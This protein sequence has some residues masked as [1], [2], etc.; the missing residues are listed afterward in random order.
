LGQNIYRQFDTVIKLHR[1]NRIT[2]PIWNEILQRAR[3]GTCTSDDLQEIRSLVLTNDNC[4]VP[5]FSCAPW[6]DAILI[7]PRNSVQIRWN[8]RA[9]EKH[10]MLSGEI[11]YICPAEDSTSQG[12]LSPSQ[13]LTAAAMPLKDTEQLP[14]MI[15]IVK[16]MRVMVTRNISTAANLSNGSRGRIVDIIL[17]PREPPVDKRAIEEKR[18]YLHYPPILVIVKLDFCE[19]PQLPGLPPCHVP[20]SPVNCKFTMGSTPSTRITR[21]QLPLIP[22]YAFTDF[23]S[24]GQTIEHVLVDI[25]KT[26]CFAL[27]PFNAYVA[28]SRSRGRETIRLLRDFDDKL[29]IRHPSEDLR[30]EDERIDALAKETSTHYAKGKYGPIS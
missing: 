5:D 30:I 9:T 12:P 11:M 20:L 6:N 14:T 16:G 3:T 28:L 25:G 18:T 15:R 13:R 21:R 10:S 4:I 22:A 8:A 26:T 1:Q 19:L 17:D 2:D 7:T 29:F 23:K 27:S 24:Q